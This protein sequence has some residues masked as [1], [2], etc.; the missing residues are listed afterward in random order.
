MQFAGLY[1]R[2]LQ[3]VVISCSFLALIFTAC[4]KAA[5]GKL[6]RE[7]LFSIKYGNFED[8]LDM[9]HLSSPYIR[10][11]SQLAMD[12]GIFYISNSSAGKIMKLTSFGDLLALYYNPEKNPPPTFIDTAQTEKITTRRA[13]TYSLNHPTYLAVT[14]NK[15]LFVV[16][17]VNDDRIE[18]DQTENLAL[19]D[20]VLHFNEVGE[21][22]DTVGQEGIGGTPFPPIE[23]LYSDSGNGIVVVC[24]TEHAVRI[25]W[26]NA[27]GSLL[28][29]I[30]VA[31]NGLPSPYSTDVKI[32]S[33][34]EKVVPDFSEKLLYFKIDYYRENI[35]S[36]TNVSAGISYD[37]SC[38]Y[39]FNIETRRF[40]RKIDIAPYED[41]EN[42][43]TGTH[44][45]KKVYGFT[46]IAAHNWCFLT[47]PR[48]DGY[49]LKL[50]DLNSNKIYTRTLTVSADELVYNAFHLS[51]D[52]MLSALIA[53]NE[54]AKIVWWRT[55]EI[56]G[57]S[58]NER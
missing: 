24:R 2:V 7:D 1:K 29:K 31:L 35:D 53:G 56:T 12:D 44:H 30:P 48:P 22:I 23:G 11:D 41:S 10:P 8:Q 49:I 55:N 38:L 54:D 14:P 37:K 25:Y 28:Y 40:E 51:Q 52:G 42:T 45:F 58:K 19:R 33:S 16:D 5:A 57:V 32:F 21:C 20:M 46:G 15:H 39:I 18:Y 43:G 3:P 13:V 17:T 4:T 27:E 9:F 34:L 6:E 26:Y 47:T 50:I 36:G